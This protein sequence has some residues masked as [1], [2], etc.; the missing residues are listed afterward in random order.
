MLGNWQSSNNV[1][2]SKHLPVWSDCAAMMFCKEGQGSEAWLTGLS[3]QLVVRLAQFHRTRLANLANR[4]GR[5]SEKEGEG[6][7]IGG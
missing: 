4:S 3:L 6:I 5:E 7:I 2:V 1:A